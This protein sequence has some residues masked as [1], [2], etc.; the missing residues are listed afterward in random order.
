MLSAL[1]LALVPI[2]YALALVLAGYPAQLLPF[3]AGALGWMIALALR[4]PVILAA[5]RILGSPQRAMPV[6]IAASGPAE[7]TV[8]VIAVLLLG[9][10]PLTAL[11]LGLG[12]ATI[13]VAYTYVN[14]LAVAQLVARNDPKSQQ[15]LEM[16]P[17]IALSA[18]SPWWSAVER[19][20]VTALHIGFTLIVAVVPI[21]F[22]LTAV[23]HSAFNLGITNI[24][25]KW[26]FVA[27]EGTVCLIGAVVLVVGLVMAGVI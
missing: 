10:D 18:Q 9:R 25:K 12:W 4:T 27:I 13:E 22:L 15:A 2:V 23:I 16:L 14:V 6:I 8:R 3:I 21:L 11:W 26:S 19:A 5:A 1:L 24:A 7:E 17:P 20:G